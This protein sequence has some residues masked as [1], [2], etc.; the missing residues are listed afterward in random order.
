MKLPHA[1]AIGRVI[2]Q[3]RINL[4]REGKSWAET[5]IEMEDAIQF[6]RGEKHVRVSV[7]GFGDEQ[8]R[9]IPLLKRGAK[10]SVDGDVDYTVH[11]DRFTDIVFG[12]VRISGA[13]TVLEEAKP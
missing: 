9:L 13:I 4:D 7:R 8:M 6:D 2:R 10:I 5:M 3:G 1:H 11:S 12:Q